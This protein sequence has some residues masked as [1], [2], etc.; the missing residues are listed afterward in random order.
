M[1]E[2]YF[3]YLEHQGTIELTYWAQ[4]REEAE[5]QAQEWI[6]FSAKHNEEDVSCGIAEIIKEVQ[7]DAKEK[8]G[9]TP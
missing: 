5:K 1:N 7:S 9:I 3:A 2:K 8:T 4:T 6:D